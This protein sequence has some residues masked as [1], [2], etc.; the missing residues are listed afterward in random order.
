MQ[1]NSLVGTWKL[2]SVE[3]RYTDGS[4]VYPWGRNAIG[5]LIYCEDGYMSGVIM[6]ANRPRFAA[7]DLVGGSLEEQAQAARTYLSYCGTYEV[8]GDK[9][10]HHVEASLFPNWIGE[11]Q[12][13]FVDELV[14]DR[15]TLRTQPLLVGSK[16][17]TGY[18]IWKRG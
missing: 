14:G 17:A 6:S 11:D 3:A 4:I 7:N 13:R 10:V 9:V 8:H 1:H 5:C 18:L 12:E 15:L 2:I 16:Q